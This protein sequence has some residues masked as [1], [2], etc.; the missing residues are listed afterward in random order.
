MKKRQDELKDL[1]AAQWEDFYQQEL[2]AM[3]LLAAD[4]AR[5]LIRALQD[6]RDTWPPQAVIELGVECGKAMRNANGD[7]IEHF[8]YVDGRS[9]PLLVA[10]DLEREK[11]EKDG[12]GVWNP[13]AGLELALVKEGCGKQADYGSFF[14]FR[15][16][17][18]NVAEFKEKEE[19][20]AAFLGLEGED[21]ERAG[22]LVV[23]RFEDG[24]PVTMQTREGTHAPVPNNFD[25]RDDAHGAKCPFHAH[26]RRV[27]PRREGNAERHHLI[28][29]R[30]I[31]YGERLIDPR[32]KELLDRPSGGVGLLFM[33]YQSSLEQQFEHMQKR[34]GPAVSKQDGPGIDPVIGQGK[35]L[36]QEWPVKWGEE[37]KKAFAFESFVTLKGGEY[38]FAPSISFLQSL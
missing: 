30:G 10:E 26:I 14:V 27:N 23:G 24:T 20:L 17:E 35:G 5:A 11:N 34:A 19:Q 36:P 15:K 7:H 2:H 29:R 9:Q 22:A 4:S 33:C 16:L 12:T 21:E 3:I 28:V 13:K 38:F 25:Y 8:G 6:M 32:T 37:E 1:P 31:P 18:Q